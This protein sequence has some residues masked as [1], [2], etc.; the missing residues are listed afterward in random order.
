MPPGGDGGLADEAGH[1]PALPESAVRSPRRER[2]LRMMRQRLFNFNMSEPV[3]TR[4]EDEAGAREEA[5]PSL[6][7][8]VLQANV[9]CVRGCGG[10]MHNQTP[11]GVSDFKKT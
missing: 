10:R 2:N 5:E 9:R 3:N 8:A 6:E 7:D 11:C 1:L 4:E